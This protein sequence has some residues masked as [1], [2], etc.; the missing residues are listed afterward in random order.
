[1]QAAEGKARKNPLSQSYDRLKADAL[2]A[3]VAICNTPAAQHAAAYT[4]GQPNI[5]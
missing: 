3:G 5:S 4:Q 2:V 1:M